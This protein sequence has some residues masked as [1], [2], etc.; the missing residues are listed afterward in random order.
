ML[1][2]SRFLSPL[3]DEIEDRIGLLEDRVV[4]HLNQELLERIADLLATLLDLG[5]VARE[6][7]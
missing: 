4:R 3:L 7:S 2:R 5:R 1:D 6:D